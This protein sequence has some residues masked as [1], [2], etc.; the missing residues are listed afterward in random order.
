M[1]GAFIAAEDVPQQ[2]VVLMQ[3]ADAKHA[4]AT[5]QVALAELLYRTRLDPLQAGQLYER[6]IAANPNDPNVLQ[7]YATFLRVERRDLDRAQE[8]YERAIAVDPKNVNALI[9]FATFLRA[10]RREIRSGA[11]TV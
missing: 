3:A 8:L 9:N 4:S 1:T 10:E 11:G 7:S 2:Y 6:A 5:A